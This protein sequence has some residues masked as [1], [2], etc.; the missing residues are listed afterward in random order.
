M[1][2]SPEDTRHPDRSDH[3]QPGCEIGQSMIG[4]VR[5]PLRGRMTKAGVHEVVNNADVTDENQHGRGKP[6]Q[7]GDED[8]RLT[9][10]C[11]SRPQQDDHSCK[12]CEWR[13]CTAQ[14]P[15]GVSRDVIAAL[16]HE[17]L[18]RQRAGENHRHRPPVSSDRS[19]P[20]LLPAHTSRLI[21]QNARPR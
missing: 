21:A 17:P 8:V 7:A 2:T 11:R 10:S 20:A 15:S 1:A 5:K 6:R 4:D 12:G 9:P 19:Q 14:M 18:S 16:E 13:C 3:G